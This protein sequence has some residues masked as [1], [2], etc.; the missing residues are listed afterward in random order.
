MFRGRCR[1][2]I[3]LLLLLCLLGASRASAGEPLPEITLSGSSDV[4][5]S[6]LGRWLQLIYTDAFAR[7]GYSFKYLALPMRR[8][9]AAS[10]S[11]LS[12]GEINRLYD[13]DTFEPSLVRV[14]EPHFI[15]RYVAYAA[16]PG[17]RMNGWASLAGKGWTV[18][19][20]AGTRRPEKML[21][22]VLPKEE[23]V[24]TMNLDAGMHMLYLKRI[25]LLIYS[26]PL[27]QDWLRRHEDPSID[28]SV[29]YVAGELEPVT[30]H[31][32]LARKY[33]DLAPKL[34][35]ILRKMRKDGLIEQYRLQALASP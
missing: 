3:G 23:M 6:Y 18:G 32:F 27:M 16:R 5:N 15:T 33:A 9:G 10:S 19:Y 28:T 31:V 20:L 13:Y 8:S 17:F 11:G 14:E 35:E 21:T 29:F 12:D 1:W 7:L 25:D 22:S 24:A 26:E 30:Y 34:S 2:T 4:K